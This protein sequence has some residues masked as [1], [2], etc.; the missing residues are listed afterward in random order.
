MITSLTFSPDSKHFAYVGLK[1]KNKYYISY[2]NQISEI[3]NWAGEL[4]FSPDSK[5]FAY[6][7]HNNC[8]EVMCSEDNLIYDDQKTELYYMVY[9]MQ[10]NKDNFLQYIYEKDDK[11]YFKQID[12]NVK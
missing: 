3:P 12:L 2:D 9:D 10:I 7:S 8:N 6:V 1:H 11:I 5:H 4:T